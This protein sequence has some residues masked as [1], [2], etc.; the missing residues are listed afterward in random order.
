MKT[1]KEKIEDILEKMK[2]LSLDIVQDMEL[3]AEF[4]NNVSCYVNKELYKEFDS[5]QNKLDKLYTKRIKEEEAQL[6]FAF[7]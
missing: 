4:E 5:L 3:H 2:D 6:K 7:K 1:I